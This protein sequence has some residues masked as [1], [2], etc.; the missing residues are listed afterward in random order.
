[1]Y[2]YIARGVNYATHWV[3]NRDLLWSPGVC[4]NYVRNNTV[5][6]LLWPATMYSQARTQ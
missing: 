6:G 3:T 1:M 4:V 5:L 2:M